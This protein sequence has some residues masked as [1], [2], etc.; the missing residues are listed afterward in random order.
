MILFRVFGPRYWQPI[1]RPEIFKAA[2]RDGCPHLAQGDLVAIGSILA[3]SGPQVWILLGQ[4][5]QLF[6]DRLAHN[7][8]GRRVC[9][10]SRPLESQLECPVNSDLKL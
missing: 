8:S 10:I 5:I 3:L 6:F 9:R 7:L 2:C 1:Q 4:S